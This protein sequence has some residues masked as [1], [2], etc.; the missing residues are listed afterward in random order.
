M[1]ESFGVPAPGSV[2]A[3]RGEGA[4]VNGEVVVWGEEGS[5]LAGAVDVRETVVQPA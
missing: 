4:A 3:E 5:G 1:A 2:E